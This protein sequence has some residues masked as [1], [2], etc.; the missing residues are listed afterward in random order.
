MEQ[1]ARRTLETGLCACG[2][3]AIIKKW[4][5]GDSTRLNRF[6]IGHQ[7]RGRKRPDFSA[8]LRENAKGSAD[9][10]RHPTG[11][12]H[13]NWKGGV[14]EREHLERNSARYRTW[15]DA[16][17]LRDGWRCVVCGK[18]C[19]K[20]DIAADHIVPWNEVPRLRYEVS[21]GRTLCRACHAHRH[22]LGLDIRR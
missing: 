10:R 14:S 15:R 18:K 21:N 13:W 7:N 2:C 4:T 16:V 1:K 8:W 3:G 22:G 20:G 12:A 6:V 17:Y 19:Q 5:G 11:E 9:C